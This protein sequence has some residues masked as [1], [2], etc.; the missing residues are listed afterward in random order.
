M[1]CPRLQDLPSPQACK[2]GWPWTEESPPVPETMQDGSPWPKITIITPSFNQS[3]FIEETIRSVLLQGYPDIQYM[4]FDGGST[5]NSVDIIKKYEKWI[6]YWESK[7]DRGQSHAINKGFTK[8]RGEIVA[9]IN[10]DDFYCQNAFCTSAGWLSKEEG[11]YFIYGD[12]HVIDEE[13]G[14]I[15]YYKGKFYSSQDFKAYWKHYIPQPSAFFLSDVI[16]DVGLLDEGLDFV[17]DYDFWLRCSLKYFL[18]YTNEAIANFRIHAVS[19]T[20][21]H[22]ESFDVELDR[23]VRRYWGKPLSPAYWRYW[24]SRNRFRS[25]VLRWNAYKAMQQGNLK[26]CLEQIIKSIIYYPPFFLD[27]KFYRRDNLKDKYLPFLSGLMF[28]GSKRCQ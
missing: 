11:I 9:W 21:A 19:K 3:A 13:G 20:S 1:H 27:R 26:K 15:D 28:P 25:G 17:M 2:T 12:C 16:R 5:D 4:I 7:P 14:R 24:F 6:E 10:S 8:A 23:A 22:K 18:Y